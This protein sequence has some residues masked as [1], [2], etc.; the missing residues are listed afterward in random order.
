VT[1]LPAQTH[2]AFSNGLY[3][4]GTVR[5]RTGRARMSASPPTVGSATGVSGS[6]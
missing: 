3:W 5:H 2:T 1:V 4:S 6:F